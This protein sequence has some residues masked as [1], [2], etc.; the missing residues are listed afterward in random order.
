MHIHRQLD[1]PNII[2]CYDIIEKNNFYYFILEHCPHGT[3]DSFIKK[4]QKLTESTA[5]GIMEQIIAGYKYLLKQ[6][7]LHR[8][9]KPP[10][11]LKSGPN[12]KICDFGFSVMGKKNLVGEINVGTPAYMAP[13]AL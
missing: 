3:L 11:I 6:K 13:E 7:V 9:L 2:K 5:I 12:W 8:D 10:N 4:H 1:H